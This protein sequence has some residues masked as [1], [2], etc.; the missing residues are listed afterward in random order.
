MEKNKNIRIMLVDDHTIVRQGLNFFLSKV[1]NFE[2]VAEAENGV[3]AIQMAMEC[4]PDVILMDLIMPDMSGIEAIKKIRI[5][6]DKIEILVLTSFIDDEK[7][8]QAIQNG[9]AGYLLKDVKPTELVRAV[10]A[11]ANGEVYLHPEAVRFL[12]HSMR[13]PARQEVHI[14][15]LTDREIDVLKLMARG[16]SNKD[17]CEDLGISI[18]T[19]KAHVS[20]ILQ[21]LQMANRVQA[22]IYALHQNIIPFDKWE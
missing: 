10:R 13:S 8:I 21:K 9:A 18:K 3:E 11:T 16:L 17:I 6:S 20:N 2:I 5:F 14:E 7:V 19:V 15:N 22:V 1:D 12:A 4:R